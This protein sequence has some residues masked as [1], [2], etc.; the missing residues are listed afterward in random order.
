MLIKLLNYTFPLL[1]IIFDVVLSPE[2]ILEPLIEE[3]LM[4]IQG[5][6]SS[7]KE[8]SSVSE[9]YGSLNKLNVFPYFN[10]KN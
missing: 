8:A 9:Y 6:L 7:F 4:L 5:S 1:M 10:R 2:M 3:L